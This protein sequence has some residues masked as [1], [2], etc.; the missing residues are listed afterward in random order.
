[1]VITTQ[2]GDRGVLTVDT[3]RHGLM[4]PSGVADYPTSPAQVRGKDSHWARLASRDLNHS[5]VVSSGDYII[6]SSDPSLHST[7]N[8]Q[9]RE[10][11]PHTS[12]SQN[13]NHI[14]APLN[15][16]NLQ[17]R[18]QSHNLETNIILRHTHT[19]L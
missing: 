7:N 15:T 17:N 11:Q 1:M 16:Y 13:Y 18:K 8:L 5:I 14:S 9:L 19:H 4:L 10:H 12:V 2:H 6:S 3:D